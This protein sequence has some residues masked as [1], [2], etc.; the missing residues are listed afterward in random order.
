[1]RLWSALSRPTARPPT[2]RTSH[3]TSAAPQAPTVS[4][5][6]ASPRLTPSHELRA[7]AVDVGGGALLD[8]LAR[9]RR[10]QAN[11]CS[12]FSL[13]QERRPG[14]SACEARATGGGGV[15]PEPS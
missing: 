12:S 9:C 10:C 1:M 4:R 13:P 5:A 7:L 15:G 8:D 6:A 2:Q 3:R 11:A 14:G